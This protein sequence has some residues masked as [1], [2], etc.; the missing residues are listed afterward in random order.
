[1]STNPGGN[2]RANMMGAHKPAFE[3]S[4]ITLLDYFA[5]AAL[6]GQNIQ[7]NPAV[8]AEAAYKVAREMMRVREQ[9]RAGI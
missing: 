2:E 8:L 3:N 4:V 6:P 1:M 5:A 7:G 9:V